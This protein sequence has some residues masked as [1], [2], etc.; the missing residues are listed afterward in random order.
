MSKRHPNHRLAKIHRS[1]T[2]DEIASLFCVHRNT[3]RQWIKQG[4]STSD[5][6]RPMLIL[7]R[8]LSAFLQA[9]RMKHKRPCAP[10]EIYCV[11][12]R[13]PKEP[14]AR[15][16]EYRPLTATLGNLVGICPCCEILMYRRASLAKLE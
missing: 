10:G 1:Y 7:G 15:M 2:V 6:K 16:A 13:A 12:C 3:V 4:L 14:A 8:D 11:R 5:D 9:K